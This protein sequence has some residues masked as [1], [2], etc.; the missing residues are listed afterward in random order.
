MSSGTIEVLVGELQVPPTDAPPPRDL[1]DPVPLEMDALVQAQSPTGGV[2][3]FTT[4]GVNFKNNKVFLNGESL[5]YLRG[6]GH[7][8]PAEEG[9]QKVPI[10]AGILKAGLNKLRF[11]SGRDVSGAGVGAR[12]DTYTVQAV[13]LTFYSR[14]DSSGWGIEH[15]AGLGILLG[16]LAV[17]LV[18]WRKD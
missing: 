2:L 11:T 13:R 8:R 15:L 18:W 14:E 10:P 12:Y 4:R 9:D 16:V 1:E 7:G 3:V 17:V 5:G 6:P